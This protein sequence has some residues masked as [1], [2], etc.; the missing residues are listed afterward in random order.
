[1][2]ML[3]QDD[4][5]ALTNHLQRHWDEPT[6]DRE[7]DRDIER[8]RRHLFRAIG[9]NGTK[10]AGKVLG[11]APGAGHRHDGDPDLNQ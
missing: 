11:C 3:E 2:W 4:A 10:S 9:P 8:L 1:M 5:A 7:D 6:R